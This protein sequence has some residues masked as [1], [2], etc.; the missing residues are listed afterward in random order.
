MRCVIRPCSRRGFGDERDFTSERSEVKSRIGPPVC[1]YVK[2]R[3]RSEV[4]SAYKTTDNIL[5][6][7]ISFVL[8]SS[9]SRYNKKIVAAS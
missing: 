4:K 6:A 2:K 8:Y 5:K 1:A 7:F 9:I 3:G